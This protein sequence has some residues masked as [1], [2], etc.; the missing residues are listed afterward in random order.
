MVLSDKIKASKKAYR[1]SHKDEMKAYRESHKDEIK[2]SKKAYRESHKDEIKSYQKAYDEYRNKTPSH[3]K[4]MKICSWKSYGLI[5]ND[6]NKLYESYLQST[7]CNI[8]KSEYKDS[9]D[10]CMDHDHKTG[11]FRQFLCQP[12]NRNDAWCHFYIKA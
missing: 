4:T 5:H 12:C 11:L 6:Y 7:H 3:K 2:A 1:E 8:C 9:S 10:R